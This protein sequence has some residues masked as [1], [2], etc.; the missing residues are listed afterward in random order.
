MKIRDQQNINYL[1][2]SFSIEMEAFEKYYES[3]GLQ[4]TP[5]I[6]TEMLSVQH[7]C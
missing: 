3:Y 2:T 7:I 1:S 6:L 5:C 4:R